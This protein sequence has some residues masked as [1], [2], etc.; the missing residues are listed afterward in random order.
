MRA[1][2]DTNIYISALAIPGGAAE[3]AMRLAINGRFELA[4]SHAILDEVLEVLSR[5]FARDAEELARTAIFLSSLAVYV[6]PTER[7]RVLAD[8]PDNRVLECALAADAE[9]IVT[10]DE[11]I[12]ALGAWQ[13]IEIVSLRQ[14]LER[15]DNGV[16]E[17]RATYVVPAPSPQLSSHELAFLGKLLKKRARHFP[18]ILS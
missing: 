10:G 14:F 16:R 3:R 8:E 12:L 11:E 9:V 13:G 17:S 2:F 7:I 4:L 1:V 5:K 6:A 15:L 18:S